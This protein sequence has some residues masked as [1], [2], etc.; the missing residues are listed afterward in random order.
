MRSGAWAV[1]TDIE[2]I[3]PCMPGAHL[4]EVRGDEYHG[5]VKV[6]VGPITAQYR[7]K[8]SFV[9]RDD[10]GYRA[11]IRRVFRA[12]AWPPPLVGVVLLLL[13]ATA[14]LARLR[15]SRR[16]ARRQRRA[17]HQGSPQPVRGA[18]PAPRGTS[19]KF[20]ALCAP[21]MRPACP[22]AIARGAR[23]SL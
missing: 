9:E 12:T 16:P 21:S 1:L 11:F 22:S 18:S 13:L 3:A 19:R 5:V 17:A 10:A 23:R 20:R 2:R 7:G 4:E 14:I 8:A 6:K 15:I